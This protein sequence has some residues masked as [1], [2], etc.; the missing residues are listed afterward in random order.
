MTE[1][2]DESTTRPLSPE[3]RRA[4]E[5]DA[6]GKH[7]EALSALV[8]GVHKKDVEAVTRLGKRL[9]VGD[10]APYLPSDGARFLVEASDDGGAEAAAIASVLLATGVAGGRQDLPGALA[11]LA[12]AAERGFVSARGQLLALAGEDPPDA[13][14]PEAPAH[15]RA[16]A[17]RIDVSAWQ[18]APPAVDLSTNPT[19]RS[20]PAFVSEQVCRWFIARSEG[21]LK[22][23]LVYEAL[24]RKTIEHETRTNTAATFNMLETDLVFVLV[25]ARMAACLGIPFRHLEAT[26]V[27]HYAEGEEITEHFDFVDPNVPNYDEEIAQNGQRV[28]TFLVYLNDN[29]SGGETE[30]PRLGITHKGRAGEGLFFV[31]AFRDGSSD[32][33][34][35][36]AGRPPAGGE[37]WVISQFVRSRPTF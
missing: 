24:A 28:V 10:R 12:L 23:A 21:R 14:P 25:Q 31:N 6:A 2:L 4:D 1:T 35:L 3:V 32:T 11:R 34:M 22:R 13:E 15:W 9:L 29:Y 26:A 18:T 20:F 33:R 36:H 37:K 30:F 19:I 17:E 27:L 8:A 7:S 16:L 5:L